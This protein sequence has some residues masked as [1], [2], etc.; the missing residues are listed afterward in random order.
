LCHVGELPDYIYRLLCGKAQDQLVRIWQDGA[1][2]VGI[3]ISHLFDNTFAVY[4]RPAERGS[5]GEIIMLETAAA[6]TRRSIQQHGGEE[7]SVIIDVWDKDEIRQAQLRRIGFA[8]YRVWG[9]L[10]ERS[11]SAPIPDP[12]LLPGF[13]IRSATPDDAERYIAAYN[14]AFQGSWRVQDYRDC[15]MHKPGYHPDHVRA[16]VAPDGRFASFTVLW[17][18]EINHVGLFEPLG[19]HPDFQRRGLARS[20]MLHCLHDMQRRGMKTVKVGYDATN[21]AADQL[22][23]GIGFAH[24]YATLGYRQP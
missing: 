24:K 23:R 22:Y 7:T 15:V 13:T 12:Q 18:D 6:V 4:V 9:H 21:A 11:L 20:L 1:D 8:E 17:L 5:D 14:A 16:V 19:T 2:I 10:T 3:S